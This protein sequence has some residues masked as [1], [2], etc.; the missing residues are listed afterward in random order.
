MRAP[1]DEYRRLLRYYL[2]EL[3]AAMLRS[4]CR[5]SGLLRIS[6]STPPTAAIDASIA[7]NVAG[8]TCS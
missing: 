1:I 3:S 6:A 5:V 2:F 8:P 4:S 7:Q